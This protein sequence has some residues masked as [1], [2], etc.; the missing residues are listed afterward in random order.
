MKA[1]LLVAVLLGQSDEF[2]K[3]VQ[4]ETFKSGDKD[5]HRVK[6]DGGLLFRDFGGVPKVEL[7]GKAIRITQDGKVVLEAQLPALEAPLQL[8]PVALKDAAGAKVESKIADGQVTAT[9][10]GKVVYQ[11]PGSN[12]SSRVE[13]VSKNGVT[14]RFA[15]VIVDGKVVYRA[16]EA[17]P[18]ADKA[19]KD[20]YVN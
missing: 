7:V 3:R 19:N 11:G 20:G 9:I 5:F 10:D 14:R 12:V 15:E 18:D 8:P 1:I 13:S 2:E 4:V 6:V 17:I 16:G